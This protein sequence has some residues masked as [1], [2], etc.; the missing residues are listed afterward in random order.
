MFRKLV[1][2]SDCGFLGCRFS[3]QD[4]DEECE[5]KMRTRIINEGA[6]PGARWLNCTRG[7]WSELNS[8]FMKDKGSE[9]PKGTVAFVK[10]LRKCPYFF[11]YHPG[12]LPTEHRELQREAKTYRLLT[13]N[14]LLSAAIGAGAAILAQ[15]LAG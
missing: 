10:T 6:H 14:M 7:I 2:C 1:R 3:S 12:Y 5:P 4:E 9:R 11:T 15:H 8:D 13:R